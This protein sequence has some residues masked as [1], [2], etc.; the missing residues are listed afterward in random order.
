MHLL[1]KEALP[2]HIGKRNGS[3]M[4]CWCPSKI[5]SSKHEQ[6]IALKQIENMRGH[7]FI[8]LGQQDHVFLGSALHFIQRT[9]FTYVFANI[10][11]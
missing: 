4:V 8:S 11:R 5:N 1:Y 2:A 10:R 7:W 9:W 3:P 6:N